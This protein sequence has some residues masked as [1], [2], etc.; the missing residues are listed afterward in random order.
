MHM[1]MVMEQ[2]FSESI[3]TLSI[4]A[5]ETLSPKALSTAW[6]LSSLAALYAFLASSSPFVPS[7]STILLYNSI[8][9]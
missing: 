9:K 7:L 4:S 6:S 1:D 8:C 5:E 2:E 3:L